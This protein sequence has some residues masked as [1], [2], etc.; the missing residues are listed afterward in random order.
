MQ[1]STYGRHI[2]TDFW[3]VEFSVLNDLELL[4]QHMIEAAEHSGAK[5][6]SVSSEKFDPFGC[7]ILL[8]LSESHMSIHTYPEKKFAAIDCFTCGYDKIPQLAIE[9][10]KLKLKPKELSAIRLIRGLH[11]IEI[12]DD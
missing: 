3:G 2:I 5:V 12:I 1:Y 9:Y 10:L 6:L 7:T 11:G 8:L 4:K